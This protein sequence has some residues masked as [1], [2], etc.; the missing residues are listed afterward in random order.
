MI[1]AEHAIE[2]FYSACAARFPENQKFWLG[3][4]KEE[5]AHAALLIG[6][7]QALSKKPDA[8]SIGKMSPL[9]AIQAAVGRIYA[10]LAKL[11]AGSLTEK[12]ALLF[13]YEFESTTL[14]REYWEVVQTNNP[15]LLAA[16]LKLRNAGGDHRDQIRKQMQETKRPENG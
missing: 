16:F 9:T 11:N 7:A 3:L 14:E 5:S 13:A 10:S 15:D 2:K 12:N 8:F 6:M 4:G 1:E